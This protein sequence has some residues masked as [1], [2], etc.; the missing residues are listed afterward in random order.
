M[1]GK[2]KSE[3]ERGVNPLELGATEL[4][5]Q[6][7]KSYWEAIWDDVRKRATAIIATWVL[8]V[9]AFIAVFA[10]MITNHRPYVAAAPV[11]GPDAVPG[12]TELVFPLFRSLAIV[13]WSLMSAF[14]GA[15]WLIFWRRSL[16]R[17]EGKSNPVTLL[18]FLAYSV[19]PIVWG[20]LAVPWERR[21]TIGLPAWWWW[22]CF[23]A[24]GVFGIIGLGY[25]AYILAT[26]RQDA[27]GR[28]RTGS[29]LRAAY[30][31]M[32][33]CVIGGSAFGTLNRPK[34]DATDYYDDFVVKAE[35][36]TWALFPPNPHNYLESEN[37]ARKQGPLAPKLRF[38]E[39]SGSDA[40][41]VLCLNDDSLEA[42]IRLV[43]RVPGSSLTLNTP[44][45]ELVDEV[46]DG[47]L[48]ESGRGRL[49]V[50][51]HN[52]KPTRVSLRDAETLG[53]IVD[54]LSAAGIK[55]NRRTK[56]KEVNYTVS[57]D[58]NSGL[59]FQDMTTRR[60]I[61]WLGTE[62]SGAD[63]A[64]RIIM[65]TRVALS[66]GF[67]STGI[68]V[69]IGVVFGAI[70]G[71]FGGWVDVVGMRIIEIFMAIPRL[72]LLL[73]IIAFLPPEWGPYMLYAM[74]VVIGLTSWMSSARFIRAEF[75]RLR[76][77]DY[78]QAAKACG[79]PLRSILFKHML[80]NGVAPVLVSASF[81]VAA[82]IF[83]ETGLSFLGFGIK[84]PNPS[85]GQMLNEAVDPDI[86]VFYWWLAIFPGILIF[87]TVFSFNLIGDALRDAIDPKLKK[88]SAV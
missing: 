46:P 11:T 36:G 42:G 45:S 54:Q 51:T 30:L 31:G 14:I 27:F 72:F 83:I 29:A 34:L 86:G 80:P 82:A 41:D 47:G 6:D 28:E 81:G 62:D 37:Y 10:P 69:I 26:G 43:D 64:A 55:T 15:V 88:A 23:G 75:F 52:L 84:P 13:D 7:S 1:S 33:M 77:S 22:A 61:H 49:I 59:V 67:V 73:T 12:A 71:Y 53:D 56:E 38:M 70:I 60:P 16:R 85:W 40:C 35:E 9:L 8:V 24:L 48:V 44:L 58:A 21:T 2:S 76:E 18:L 5:I 66:I 20:L 57:L 78:V 19:L 65:A 63:V 4:L 25:G 32:L 39:S 17:S 50:V 3:F 68:A 74:M 87:V 79:L